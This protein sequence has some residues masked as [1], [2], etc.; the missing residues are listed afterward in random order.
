M[1]VD[2]LEQT[3]TLVGDSRATF[4]SKTFG[5]TL[6]DRIDQKVALQL[7]AIR[8]LFDVD[9]GEFEWCAD[10][11]ATIELSWS[12]VKD[13]WPSENSALEESEQRLKEIDKI[14]DQIVYYCA[15]LSF[16]P[17]VNDVLCN[18][19]IG[20]PLDVEFEFGN[21][22]PKDADL[23]KR[24]LSE[25]AQESAVVE[26]G[27]VDVDQ[28]VIYRSAKTRHEQL[29]SSWRLFGWLVLGFAIP[30]SLAFGDLV[31]QGWPLHYRDLERLLVD[32]VLILIGSG[33]HL[34]V[35]ALKSAKAKTRP[36]F[37]AINDWVL[38]LNVREA[39]IRNGIFYVWL[40]YILLVFGVPDLQWSAAFF[41]GY[42]IDSVTELFLER[43]QTVVKTKAQFAS[44]IK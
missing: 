35:E 5:V 20:Q 15:S 36:S 30:V 21:E 16:S 3:S 32:Y 43:F 19:R 1:I 9:V 39:Q 6:R 10:S 14:L 28:G 25:L 38:W 37:Q 41:A 11:V 26:L 42:S 44:V 40:G 29:F 27:V 12:Q 7:T 13:L 24:L 4:L 31:L 22:F 34:A 8:K 17:R 2:A 18:L 23:R 33:G